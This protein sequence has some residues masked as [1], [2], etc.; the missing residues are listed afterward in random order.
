MLHMHP[1]F[2]FKINS[3]VSRRKPGKEKMQ[4]EQDFSYAMHAQYQ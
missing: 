3:Y 4:S 2:S 1:D